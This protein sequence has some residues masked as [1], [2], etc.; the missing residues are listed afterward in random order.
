MI[1]VL[2]NENMMK[3]LLSFELELPMKTNRITILE[4]QVKASL[5]PK[6]NIYRQK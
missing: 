3:V 6:K 5:Y 2:L 4:T 1:H